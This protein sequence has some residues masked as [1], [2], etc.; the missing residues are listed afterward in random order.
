MNKI[1]SWVV[2][3]AVIIGMVFTMSLTLSSTI[4]MQVS[5]KGLVKEAINKTASNYGVGGLAKNS[6]SILNALGIEDQIFDQL[7]KKLQVKT[8]YLDLYDLTSS[9]QKEG[10]IS[11]SQLNMPNTTDSQ[12]TVSDLVTKYINT[13]LEQNQDDINQAISYYKMIFYV[14][15]ALYLIGMILVLFGKRFGIYPFLLASLG[16]YALIAFVTGQLQT[17]LQSEIYQGITVTMANGFNT[18]IVI[19]I[20]ITIVWF[21]AATLKKHAQNKKSKKTYAGKHAAN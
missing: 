7:P 21:W 9:Y 3:I 6:W 4:S 11:A 14:I 18:S 12:K 15:I 20:I 16:G 19:A 5:T 17:Q 2:R 1:I 10:K 8:S 13:A